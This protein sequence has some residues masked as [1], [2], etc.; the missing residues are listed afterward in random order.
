MWTRE[1]DMIGYIDLSLS[2]IQSRQQL[3]LPQ[4]KQESNAA[5]SAKQDF[6]QADDGGRS[7]F[8]I[9]EPR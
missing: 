8:D 1:F 7:H 3:S 9:K 4:Q 2:S 6:Q 5:Q